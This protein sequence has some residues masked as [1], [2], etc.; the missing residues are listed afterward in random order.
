M[1]NNYPTIKLSDEQIKKF[2]EQEAMA[3]NFILCRKLA[4]DLIEAGDKEWAYHLFN[5]AEK[6]AKNFSNYCT[7]GRY[8]GDDKY[9]G[10][11]E[12]ARKLFKESE[13]HAKNSRNFIRLAESVMNDK[14]LGDKEWASKLAKIT[15]KLARK[16]IEMCKNG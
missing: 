3:N 6:F 8:V 5:K 2:K 10:E 15:I 14:Y 13:N 11:K 1:V 4:V 12:W 9:L 16:E 7:L